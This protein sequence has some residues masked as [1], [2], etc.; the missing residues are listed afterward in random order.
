MF[1]ICNKF[2][3]MYCCLFIVFFNVL[4]EGVKDDWRIKE[5]YINWKEVFE[6]VLYKVVNMDFECFIV[7]DVFKKFLEEYK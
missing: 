2:N 5:E 6:Y 4:F 1:K 7:F 3:G